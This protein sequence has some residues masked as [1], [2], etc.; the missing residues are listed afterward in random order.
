MSS[1]PGTHEEIK[2]DGTAKNAD[3]DLDSLPTQGLFKMADR[4]LNIL[5]N[6]LRAR[7][8]KARFEL[9]MELNRPRTVKQYQYV[10]FYPMPGNSHL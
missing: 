3:D 7:E 5:Q 6:R 9:N 8:A 4:V 1:D 2:D 10:P